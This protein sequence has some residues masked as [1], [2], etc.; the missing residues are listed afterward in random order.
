MIV[1]TFVTG[2][3]KKAEY[4]SKCIGIPL[5]HE[6]IDLEE[7]QTL[8]IHHV[9]KH[10]LDQAYKKLLK[11]VLVEDL[12]FELVGLN[13]LPGTFIK[14]FLQT[15]PMQ[16]ICDLIQ[17]KSREVIVRSVIGYQDSERVKL[18]EK[19]SLGTVTQNPRGNGGFGWDSIYIPDGYA[20]TR[21]EMNIEDD[22]TTYKALKP[23]E[24]LRSFLVSLE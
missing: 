12:A 20:V 10:K 1:P 5:S 16:D 3:P 11:P 7:I 21:A 9:T 17:N 19:V 23:F 4:F 22:A 15:L 13:G 8:N 24:E 14:F 18:F 6:A 2:N